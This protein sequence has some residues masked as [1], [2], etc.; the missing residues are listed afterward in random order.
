MVVGLPVRRGFACYPP[1]AVV[2][3]KMI[4]AD[5][6]IAD[7]INERVTRNKSRRLV[8]KHTK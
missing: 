2:K 8:F 5:N 1:N 7:N 6:I 3:M 4:I